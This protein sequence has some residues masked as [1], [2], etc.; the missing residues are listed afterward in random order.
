MSRPETQSALLVSG[1]GNAHS[2]TQLPVQHNGGSLVAGRRGDSVAQYGHQRD[3]A[4][5]KGDSQ[6]TLKF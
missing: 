5:T 3:A 2:G 4:T 1:V 6:D